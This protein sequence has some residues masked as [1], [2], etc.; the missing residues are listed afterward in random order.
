MCCI[1][2]K[3]FRF[4]LPCVARPGCR[5]AF[6]ALGIIFLLLVD[7]PAFAQAIAG[8][9]LLFD[10]TNDYVT[11][12]HSA[13]LDAFPLT[14][15]AWIKTLRNS[16]QVDGIV[17][18]YADGTFNGYSINLRN[19][20]LYGWY[21]QSSANGMWTPP[22]GLDG[23]FI[24]DGQWHHVAFVVGRTT[25]AFYIDGVL[26]SSVPWSGT[27]TATFTA[28][29]LQIGRYDDYTNT[30]QGE[31]DDI[32]LW[33]R[34]LTSS[35]INYLKHRRLA[36]S[37]DGLLAYYR[38][39]ESGGTVVTNSAGSNFF[40]TAINGPTRVASD[41]AVAL[42]PVAANCLKFDGVNGYL[43]VPHA[44]ELNA[45]PLTVSAWFRTENPTLFQCIA[46]KYADASDNGWTLAVQNGK[47]RG[48]HRTISGIADITSAATVA[49]GAWHHA[50]MIVDA[51]G[52][53]LLL[54]GAVVAT[55]G[56]TGTPSAPTSTEPLLIGRYYNYTSRFQGALDEVRIWNRAL[57][58]SEIQ[59]LK[60]LP[61]VGNETGLI[62]YW[63]LDEGSGA[64]TTVDSTGH[65]HTGTLLSNPEWTGSTA[66]L[67]D[68]SVH[69]VES[70]GIPNFT[71]TFA[72]SSIPAEKSFVVKG[73]DYL[74]R[75]HDFGPAPATLPVT[76][77]LD[78]G[79]RIAGP[80]T[81]V[82]VKSNPTI[83]DLN[84]TAYN[85][86][87]P[88]PSRIFGSVAPI[89]T[90][91][92]I[93]PDNIQLDSVDALYEG[94]VALSHNENGGAFASDGDEATDATRLLHFNG[95]IWFGPVQTVFTNL[96]TASSGNV[97]A[98]NYLQSPI[99]L[100]ANTGHVAGYPAVQFGGG[101]FTVNLGTDGTATNVNGVF[102]LATA[103]QFFDAS[104]IRYQLGG[105]TLSS[106]GMTAA[107]LSTWFPTGFGMTTNTN[108][109]VL[110][111]FVTKSNIVL[112]GDLLPDTSNVI[113][114]AASLGVSR[115]YFSEETK[116]LLIGAS[117]IEWHIS[118]GEFYIS[119]AASVDFVRQRD[120]DDLHD[121]RGNLVEPLAGDR[122][123]NDNYFHNVIAKAGTPVFVRADANGAALL[124][125][126]AT[127]QENEFR[128]HFPYMNRNIG[129]HIPMIG[130][131]LVITNDLV[132]SSA[133]HIL[134]ASTVP[135]PYARDCGPEA[136]CDN[137]VTI[138]PEILQF[139]APPGEFGAG[140]LNFTP[141]GGLLAY[142]TIP[143]ENL[144]WGFIGG[145][146]FAQRTSDVHQGAYR[147]AGTFLRGDQ[148]TVADALRPAALLFTGW[149]DSTNAAYVERPGTSAYLDG[150]ANYA[151]LNFRAPAQGRSFI[152]NQDTGFY[153]LT[154]RAKY[155][156]RYGG[157]S[158][159]HEAASF[160]SNL[161][162]YG[163][164]FTFQSYRLSFLDSAN[165]ESRTDGQV[166]LPI[167]A[168]F[169]VEFERMKFLCRGNLDAAQLPATIGTK[170][171]NYWNA[172][173]T[174]L[175]LQFKPVV[176][177]P[178]S[179]TNR[180]L[181]LGVETKL[182]L[183][184]QALHAALG[185]KPNGNLVTPMNN[186]EGVDSRFA[187]PANLNLK[188][189]GESSF[190]ITTAS[191]GYFNN[192]ET[193]G[194]PDHGFYN[195]VGRIRVPFFRDIKAQFH[196]TPSGANSAEVAV[197][198]G[199]T[200]EEGLGEQRG[201]N[202]GTQ[203]YFNTS[204]FDVNNDGW[205]AG[206]TLAGYRSQQENYRPRAQQNW[207]DVAGFDY[208]LSWNS[209][210]HDFA[211][212]APA[213]VTLPVIDVDSRLKELSPGKVDLDFAQDLD[214]KLPHIKLLD[215][216]NDAYNEINAP[217]NTISNA[218][219]DEVAGVANTVGLTSGFRSL[220]KVCR[221][222]VEG[223]FRPILEP[224]LDPVVDNLYVAFSNALA[225]SKGNLLTQTPNIVNASGL[226]TAIG[227]LN[228]TTADANKVI[229]Q[230]NQMLQDVDDTLGLFERILEKDPSSGKREIVKIII[231]KLV[232][233]QGPALGFAA[234]IGDTV[235]NDLLEQIDPT[236]EE[237]R[238]DLL[239]LHAQFD[240]IHGQLGA[241]G[242]D[243]D[244]DE[245]LD[246]ANH[247][248][249]NVYLQQAGESVSNLLS[250]VV[251]PAGDYFSANPERAKNEIRERLV[252][253]FLGSPI[254]GKYQETFRRFLSDKDFLLDQLMDVLFDQ[255][256]RSIREGL[257][258][259][260]SPLAS[261][262]DGIFQNMK[263]AGAL[264]GSLLTAKIRGAPTFEGDSLRKIH[265]DSDIKMN[266]PDEMKF[267]AYMDIKELNSQS[268]PLSCIPAGA[269]SA[270]V[271]L[272]AKDVSLDWAGVSSGTGK[273]LKLSLAA[274]W[275]L[276]QGAVLGIGGQLGIKGGAG[277]KG[278][279]MNDFEA[280]LAIG[281]TENYFAAKAAATVVILVPVNFNAAIFAGH[282]CSLDPLIAID[283]QAP[284]VL[285][286][287]TD[288]SGV[289]LQF[290]GGLSLSQILLG[291]STCLLDV[292]ANISTA[293]YYQGGPRLGSIGGRQAVD[294]SADLLCIISAEVG[295]T[296]GMRLDTA[297]QLTVSGSGKLC[298][299]VGVCPI[300]KDVCATLGITGI[301]NDGGF[302]YSIDY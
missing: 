222:N 88:Q 236:L 132:D 244:F 149:G 171:L 284:E 176:G 60:N 109:F 48:F 91:V 288:F 51:A 7:L 43:Q 238:N 289:Y 201:W 170:H 225:V 47:L 286:N 283:P 182:P 177:D 42:E 279:S 100:P 267:S 115:L 274:R 152:A 50:A 154:S 237:I 158:G 56:W 192:W 117:Q 24:A 135:V 275:T 147:L 245:S 181:V 215:L 31:M 6:V 111:P 293:L 271:T 58:T 114:D 285:P 11:V 77:R 163:Y 26:Q 212:F 65:G 13:T 5:G 155:Y 272:G 269:P 207:I 185:F 14:I 9:A 172:D 157:V 198:G 258:A 247:Q 73:R 3:R 75:F 59:S 69:L 78:G 273:S 113:F 107:S 159:I 168:G 217:I 76:V 209:V 189:P 92:L 20:H 224:A 105:A 87:E 142:G 160:P 143:S 129:D 141:D 296:V 287:A 196:I 175:S 146:N 191:E 190:P 210:L 277:F 243:S 262:K 37:E 44:N 276:Q 208:P 204:K 136:G 27:P 150:F 61:L 255:I 49:D 36:G 203:N 86:S 46:N 140:Q 126:T 193:P 83:V 179:L 63:K 253:A 38:F 89:T 121:L 16:S 156:V 290:G 81:P 292:N 281:E 119:Q 15:T 25:G 195:I 297:G 4:A 74:R 54:D 216:A 227:N 213:K 228:G 134:V 101:G 116:P 295:W 53:R 265:L 248:S 17:S 219:R 110:S 251:G 104:G 164:S 223:F 72:V 40:G 99:Q 268:T 139:T 166:A 239:E 259:P 148:S 84:M 138:G 118:Q 144:T 270:E 98:P 229:G 93:E 200:A 184:P 278:C 45:Y 260:G 161:T 234:D 133:S 97:F 180:F 62:A 199:W 218:I 220:Q 66:Y 226:D 30:F 120:D 233:D 64:T 21:F 70:P 2:E 102:G 29:P 241:V 39:N 300:C 167:P 52:L 301:V 23:G 95:T 249:L 127:L 206:V 291:T 33:N 82:V 173:L 266:L 187:L 246:I 55:T 137:P 106:A 230:L 112:D 282:A 186:V 57:S 90:D 103:G 162:L 298:A 197:M 188:G 263:G 18:K 153:P 252:M 294:V 257:T 254:T 67:G 28:Q 96:T 151:G 250:S 205:P 165:W 35:E 174:P 299:E 211:G 79:L 8:T 169:P 202:I 22:N 94:T 10:G 122:I 214:V 80:N 125:M 34:E 242:L 123:S 235:L 85:A 183:I 221:E 178:C 261:A 1:H 130:G 124:S 264:S 41:A 19:G 131:T 12:P 256:N 32:T 232:N 240:E 194:H 71:Q 231:E 128:P 145:S 302:D 280:F 108:D 68:G